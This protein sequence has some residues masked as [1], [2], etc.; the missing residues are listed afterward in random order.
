MKSL[1]IKFSI[2]LSFIL[3]ICCFV[4]L[5][6]YAEEHRCDTPYQEV[7][8]E[9]HTDVRLV[10]VPSAA[11]PVGIKIGR[12]L[13]MAPRPVKICDIYEYQLKDGCEEKL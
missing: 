13:K 10:P 8:I 7:C 1:I 4:L 9:Y 3:A 5:G 11:A 12:G 2:I 6:R